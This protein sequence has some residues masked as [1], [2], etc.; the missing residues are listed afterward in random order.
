MSQPL[1]SLRGVETY[2]GKIVALRG[3]D[4]DVNEGEIVTV[5]G[6][7]GGRQVDHHDDHLRRER[8]LA[9]ERFIYKGEDI[10]RLPHP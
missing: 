10:T 5:I 7:N 2:Y 3:I 4:I 8:V 1:L 9:P 6:A